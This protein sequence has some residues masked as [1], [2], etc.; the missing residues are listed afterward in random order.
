MGRLAI[1]AAILLTGVLR[2]GELGPPEDVSFRAV[3]DGST[4]RY[5]LLLPQ[6]FVAEQSHHLMVALHGHGSDRWQFAKH[7]SG[8]PAAARAVGA[9]YGMI[10]VC[11]DYRAKTSWMGPAAEADVVQILR[12]M[13]DR[14]A[15]GKVFLVGGS[16]GATS[17]LTFAAL[18][19]DLV[20]GVVA[21][22][23]LAN[24][25]EYERF[26]E[27]IVA[28]F[29]GT[30]REIP[31]EYKRR[32]AEYHPEAFVMPVAFTTGGKDTSVPPDSV[33]RL[34]GILRK[35]DRRVLHIHRPEG[36][37]STTIP[38]A[39]EALEFVVQQALGTTAPP[40]GGSLFA[41]QHPLSDDAEGRVELGLRVSVQAAGTLAAGWFYQARSETGQHVLRLWSQDG[42]ELARAVAPA[43]AGAGWRRVP[44]RAPVA[45]APGQILVLS[46]T[47]DSHYVATAE[48]LARPVVRDGITAEAGLYSFETLGQMPDKTYRNMNYFLDLTYEKG[49]K[50]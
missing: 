4:Q 3:V 18:H 14:Y 22:N 10:Y 50:E 5:V 20:D 39:T 37:H 34:A 23:G 9:K 11:P 13:R 49:G 7:D 6:P 43:A 48:G 27:A 1:C 44:F 32:S 16:M 8:S 45:V 24:H 30:K 33:I 26:Q 42:K 47:A 28:S 15:I 25:L 29:G 36:G 40:A 46:Y 41:G 35:L 2:A 17:A 19:P 31:V 38:D 21:C 12:A